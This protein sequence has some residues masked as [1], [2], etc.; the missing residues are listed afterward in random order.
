MNTWGTSFQQHLL[1]LL[2]QYGLKLQRSSGLLQL[3]CHHRRMLCG[4]CC[5]AFCAWYVAIIASI[6]CVNVERRM[7]SSL[8][9]RLDSLCPAHRP[10]LHAAAYALPG[11]AAAPQGSKEDHYHSLDQGPWTAAAGCC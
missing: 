5:L 6:E 8:L 2:A 10:W 9:V 7:F 11:S 3:N 4:S 1:C